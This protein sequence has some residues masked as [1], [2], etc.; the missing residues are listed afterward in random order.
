MKIKKPIIKIERAYDSFILFKNFKFR[1]KEKKLK[2]IFNP[3]KKQRKQ[4]KQ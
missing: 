4:K 1:S 2:E 3:K